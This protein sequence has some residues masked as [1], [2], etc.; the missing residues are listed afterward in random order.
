MDALSEILKAV[1]LKGAL[2]FNGEFSEPWSMQTS[3]AGTSP[4][5]FNS[6]GE[7]V[8]LYHLLSF[9]RERA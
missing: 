2:F 8:I 7:H 1:K 9:G 3:Q 5:R 6:G 4:H